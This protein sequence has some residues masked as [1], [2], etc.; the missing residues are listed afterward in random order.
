MLKTAKNFHRK[1]IKFF[2]A[3]VKMKLKKKCLVIRKK[4]ELNDQKN[5]YKSLFI[6]QFTVN[7]PS[8]LDFFII[9]NCNCNTM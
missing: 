5:I 4:K 9:Y 3:S 2:F 1:K 8:E 6:R 7:F